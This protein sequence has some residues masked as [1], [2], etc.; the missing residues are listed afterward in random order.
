MRDNGA[1][2]KTVNKKTNAVQF[3]R[4]I[5]N[6]REEKQISSIEEERKIQLEK[7]N[8]LNKPYSMF[9]DVDELDSHALRQFVDCLGD[10]SVV[11]GAIMPDAHVGYTLPIGGIVSTR[12]IV[13]PSFQGV[14]IA[15]SVSCIE[16]THSYE[17]LMHG[18]NRKKVFDQIYRDVPVGRRSHKKS[19]LNRAGA[20]F[21]AAINDTSPLAKKLMESHGKF[22]LGSLG[23]GNHFIE[24]GYC[25]KNRLYLSVHSGSRHLGNA[26]AEHYARIAHPENRKEGVYGLDA[27]SD[28]GRMFLK[29]SE[30][31]TL[32]A[33]ENHL[34]M[35]DLIVEAL[36]RHLKQGTA[37]SDTHIY[38]THNAISVDPESSLYIHRKGA[39][40]A[41]SGQYG[42]IPGNMRDGV[43]I[44]R[45]KGNRDSLYSASHGAGRVMS[46]NEAISAIAMEDFKKQMEGITAK[47]DEGTR[48]ESPAAYKNIFSVLDLQK[49]LIDVKK[50][51]RPVINCKG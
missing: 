14:D 31:C 13:F 35:I 6:T 48:D 41:N 44:V 7:L 23:G 47:V 37:I 20:A 19:Q 11:E 36:N 10:P 8:S 40:P 24:I 42:V 34:I 21:A 29:D 17:E 16:L 39:T 15:C 51:I 33:R 3:K 18:D 1:S 12:N 46:R 38:S 26:L 43:F 5:M 45:G 2:R 50:H 27:K 30:F 4:L 49:D 25:D 28:E 32:Y 22:Q 9:I